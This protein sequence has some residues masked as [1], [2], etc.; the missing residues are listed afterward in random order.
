MNRFPSIS[1]FAIFA[2]ELLS[3]NCG[4]NILRSNCIIYGVFTASSPNHGNTAKL[5]LQCATQ[6]VTEKRLQGE[7]WR[8][9][10][11]E[12]VRLTKHR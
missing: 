6:A 7:R 11:V 2:M 5:I 1:I 8:M 4:L 10:D 12:S 9:C 3:F